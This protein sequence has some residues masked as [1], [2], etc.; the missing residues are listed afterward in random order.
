MSALLLAFALA[1]TSYD[2][3]FQDS[4]AAYDEGDYEHAV[5]LLEQLVDEGIVED[6]VFY[7]LGNAYFRLGRFG[8]SIAN[9]E[10]TL[11]L[12]PNHRDARRNLEKALAECPRGLAR[13]LPPEWE[14]AVLF[15]HQGFDR[16]TSGFLA[17]AL[18][19]TGWTLLGVRRF[20]RVRY[21]AAAGAVA[22]AF[23]AL[24]GAS[25]YAKSHP[26]PTA[27]VVSEKAPVR[28]GTSPTDKVR[29]ELFEGDRVLVEAADGDWLRVATIGRER[30]WA[31]A[32][33][34]VAVGPPYAGYFERGAGEEAGP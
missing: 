16:R 27:V 12:N 13:P 17:A 21:L 31:K 29:F 8:E 32:E 7:N 2:A 33:H 30:G 3:V 26:Q 20:M 19:V 1:A 34:L 11:Q 14:Q 9:Y 25:W 10:R 23:G 6:D 4:L 18:W 28:Y 5:V 22:V 24:F 15:W